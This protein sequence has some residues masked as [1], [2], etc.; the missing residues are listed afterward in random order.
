M[1][2][3]KNNENNDASKDSK[4]MEDLLQALGISANYLA[5]K[6]GTSHGAIYHIKNGVN[7]ISNGMIE[8]IIKAFPNV[9]HKYLK[10]DHLP[11]LLNDNEVK[12]QMEL[13][14]I[15]PKNDV[16]LNTIQRYLETPN[17]LD[18]IEQKL[19]LLLKQS[20]IAYD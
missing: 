14:N 20:G 6:V 16:T 18:R 13:L 11:I 19:N 2:K 8:R 1:Q 5:E 10:Y 4:K 9:N 15:K 7:N 3:T 17:Q 12:E